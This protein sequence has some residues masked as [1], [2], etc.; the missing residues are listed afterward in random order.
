MRY[1]RSENLSGNYIREDGKLINISSIFDTDYN[2]EFIFDQE[3]EVPN[4]VKET[5]EQLE[6]NRNVYA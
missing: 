3:I 2:P 5:I 6:R 1:W 4:S